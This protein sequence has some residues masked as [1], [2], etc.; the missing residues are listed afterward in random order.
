MMMFVGSREMKKQE[1]KN[2]NFI[3]KKW[4]I[5]RTQCTYKT[6]HFMTSFSSMMPL[7]KQRKENEKREYC[8]VL[9][10]NITK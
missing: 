1:E 7:Q 10:L 8:Q 6:L 4:N 5:L 9:T 3:S 2:A